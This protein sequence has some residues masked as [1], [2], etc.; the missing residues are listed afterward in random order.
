[1]QARVLRRNG[2]FFE[3]PVFWIVGLLT[4]LGQ[5]DGD[6]SIEVR[7]IIFFIDPATKFSPFA[8]KRLVIDVDLIV[9]GLAK[10]RVRLIDRVPH[11]F[12]IPAIESD[13][14]QT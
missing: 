2:E 14:A 4:P 11:G 13:L 12:V 10:I 8:D 6:F 7:P 5:P 9:R 1:M 3:Q